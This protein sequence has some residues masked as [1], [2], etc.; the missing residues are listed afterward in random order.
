MQAETQAAT[1]SNAGSD[2]QR[3][4]IAKPR[5]SAGDGYCLI[6][7]MGLSNDKLSYNA[8]VVCYFIHINFVV[9][10]SFCSLRYMSSALAPDLNGRLL[11]LVKTKKS[12]Y[13]FLRL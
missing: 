3:T 1:A 12:S 8:I 13:E 11:T 5:G 2:N 4:T 6:D 9:I 10:C 7:K